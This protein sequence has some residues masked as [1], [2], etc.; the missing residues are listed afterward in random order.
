MAIAHS[1]DSGKDIDRGKIKAVC[2]MTGNK[3]VS[4]TPKILVW[5]KKERVLFG[6][7]SVSITT[8]HVPA[9]FTNVL[10]TCEWSGK[11]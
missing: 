9:V 4:E 7:F 10:Y 6:K 2:R 11:V 3:R 1:L 8:L 5:S